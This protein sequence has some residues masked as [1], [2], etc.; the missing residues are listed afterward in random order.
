MKN[1]G[2]GTTLIAKALNDRGIPSPSELYRSKGNGRLWR[3]KGNRCYWTACKVEAILRDEKY[4]GTM[5]Q[6]KTRLDS[7]GGR[8]VKRPKEEWVRVQDTHEAI[9]SYPQYIRAVSSLKQ[10]KA[11]ECGKQKNIYYCGYC[12]RALFNAHYGTVF[13]RQ[14]SFKTDS[15][16]K[17]IEIKKH[18]ADMAVLAAVKKEAEIYLERDKISLQAAKRNAPLSVSGRINAI[19][20]SMEA[21]QKGWMALYDRYA[22]G[23]LE[24]ELFLNEK[25]KYDADM[26]RMEEELAALRHAQEEEEDLQHGSRRKADRAMAFLEESELTE[27]MKEKLIE[28]VVV[29][30]ESR[31]EIVW[32]FGEHL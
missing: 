8:Q 18:E 19:V 3:N 2:I 11:K 6:L 15:A 27:D 20:K 28:K 10:Q 21:A 30:P 25:K 13:C 26:E 12:G 17:D 24:R 14:R 31:I 4:T 29:Y 23:N 22:D 32:K 5:V 16:C 9:V 7:V 1:A